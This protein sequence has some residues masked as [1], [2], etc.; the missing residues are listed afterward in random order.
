MR[1]VFRRARLGD[2][3]HH[4][5]VAAAEIEYFVYKDAV[6]ASKI[7][8]TAVKKFATSSDLAKTYLAF[9]LRLNDDNTSRPVFERVLTAVRKEETPE[10]WDMWSVSPLD[11]ILNANSQ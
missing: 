8:E 7:L 2:P 11:S 1:E 3:T 6:T 10:I 9:L 4:V 5:F